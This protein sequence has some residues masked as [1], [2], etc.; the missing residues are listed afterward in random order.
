MENTNKET[1][2]QYLDL[3]AMRFLEEYGHD[4]PSQEAVKNAK[5]WFVGIIADVMH[6]YMLQSVIDLETKFNINAK[7]FNYNKACNDEI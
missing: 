7:G 4:R 5:A 6:G 1:L 2:E 3:Q